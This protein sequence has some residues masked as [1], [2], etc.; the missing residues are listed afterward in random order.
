MNDLWTPA[1]MV[2]PDVRKKDGGS[3]FD[4]EM[5]TKAE[6]YTKYQRESLE[7]RRQLNARPDHVI[8]VASVEARAEMRKVLNLWREKGEIRHNPKI[9]IDYG[10]REGEMRIG[11]R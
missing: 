2:T 1:G 9:L 11:E 10:I 8:S 5:A 3:Y 7:M 6:E 4:D